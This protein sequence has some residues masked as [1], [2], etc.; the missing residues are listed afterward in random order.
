METLELNIFQKNKVLDFL[1]SCLYRGIGQ[2]ILNSNYNK[3]FLERT[4]L[5]FF[6]KIIMTLKSF[7]LFCIINNQFKN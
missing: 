4:Y 7:Y 3:Y 1:A 5:N 6:E 2:K